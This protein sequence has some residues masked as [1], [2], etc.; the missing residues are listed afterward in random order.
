MIS[1]TITSPSIKSQKDRIPRVLSRDVIKNSGQ[2][3]VK[4]L[5]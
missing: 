3:I 1:R 2:V 5:I 4:I